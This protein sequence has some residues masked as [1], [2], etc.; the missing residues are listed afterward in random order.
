MKLSKF[1]FILS[2][3]LVF[4]ACGG[5]SN[6]EPDGPDKPDKPGG[7]DK[8]STAGF[9]K[10]TEANI[11]SR[12]VQLSQNIPMQGFSLDSDGNIWY[13][14]VSH[15]NKE[16]IHVTKGMPNK[17]TAIANASSND[18]TLKYFGH[19]T[20][21]AIEEDGADR[22]IWAGCYGSANAKGEYWTEKLIGRV[23]YVKGA[24]VATNECNDYYYIGDYTDM[25]PSID[26]EH[27]LLTINYGDA[28]QSLY[29][30]FVVYKLE[31]AKKAPLTTV[32]IT[33]TDGFRTGK[34][35]STTKT[36][37]MVRAHDLTT[38]TPVA[39]PKFMKTG[40]AA[41]NKY[42]AWQGFDVNGD[43]LYYA[44]GEDNNGLTGS[45]HTGTS[46]AYITVFDMEGKVIEERTQIMAIADKDWT[47]KMGMS[48][49]GTFESEGVKVK[50]DK[51]YLGFGARGVSDNDTK[52]Y[53]DILVYDKPSK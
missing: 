5:G 50:G 31:D 45:L 9:D 48:I 8:V 39:K 42:Y 4:I 11:Y 16:E 34:P 23:K 49:Y 35:S 1:L 22:Y 14:L 53:Q 52:Y 24:K 21:T 43:R 17:G 15:G 47:G 41:T 13:T 19:G 46:Y 38:L 10:Y 20:N 3:P 6:D 28:S 7:S 26:A 44:E 40:Y 33:C 25:H 29:R 18:M 37:V 32:E 27:G 12:N 36:S 51:I 2:V 30:C